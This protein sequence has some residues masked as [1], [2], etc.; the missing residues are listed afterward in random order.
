MYPFRVFQFVPLFCL[1]TSIVAVAAALQASDLMPVTFQSAP[2]HAPIPLVD[3][4]KTT[5]AIVLRSEGTKDL[6]PMVRELQ[7][8]FKL[9]TGVDLPA[10][11]PKAAE[12]HEG[13]L[14]NLGDWDGAATLGLVGSKMPIEGFAI[15]T[16]PNAVFIVGHDDNE[17]DG[18][19]DAVSSGTAWGVSEFMERYLGA[20]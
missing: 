12:K 16:A 8:V 4:G 7:E 5:A 10:I 13:V 19:K 20:R 2:K 15:K 11:S 9:T 18:V 6:K 1:L 3:M 14:I 17:V